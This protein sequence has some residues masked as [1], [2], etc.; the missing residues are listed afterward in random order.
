MSTAFG[1]PH[2]TICTYDFDIFERL[3]QKNRWERMEESHLE[4][5]YPPSEL[6]MLLEVCGFDRIEQHPELSFGQVNGSE[7][8]IFIIARK[9]K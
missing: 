8:R 6:C 9:R 3:G 5:Y 1:R 7:D 4:R 2:G